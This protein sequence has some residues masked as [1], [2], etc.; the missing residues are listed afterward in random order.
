V[1]NGPLHAGFVWIPSFDRDDRSLF[2]Q[3]RAILPFPPDQPC[4][5]MVLFTKFGEVELIG[6]LFAAATFLSR[7]FSGVSHCWAF[8]FGYWS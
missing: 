7:P 8:W 4:L 2:C 3:G 6:V 1:S 5:V